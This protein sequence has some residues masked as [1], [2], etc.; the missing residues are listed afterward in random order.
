MVENIRHTLFMY[1]AMKYFDRMKSPLSA[2]RVKEELTREEIRLR[3]SKRDPPQCSLTGLSSSL[4]HSNLTHNGVERGLFLQGRLLNHKPCKACIIDLEESMFNGTFDSKRHREYWIV[5]GD[6][7]SVYRAAS[8]SVVHLE[9]LFHGPL[10]YIY[11][12]SPM[13]SGNWHLHAGQTPRC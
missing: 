12:A 9:S 3:G 10:L 2:L 7:P 11:T 6:T 4:S 13:M 1:L 5:S 8:Y